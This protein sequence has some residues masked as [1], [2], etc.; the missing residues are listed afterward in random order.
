MGIALLAGLA[1]SWPQEFAASVLAGPRTQQDAAAAPALRYLDR[2]ASRFPRLGPHAHVPAH[3]PRARVLA[4]AAGTALLLGCLMLAELSW[5]VTAA[6]AFLV[7]F[8]LPLAVIDFQ[9]RRLPDA[10]TGPAYATV[11]ACLAG[12]SAAA[13]SWHMFGRALLGGALLAACYLMIALIWPGHMGAGDAKAAASVGTVL[14][15]IGWPVL[16]TGSLAALLLAGVC[17]G[18]LL[19][20]RRANIRAQIPFGPFLYGGAYL[21]VLVTAR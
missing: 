21:A 15:W 18:G 7:V 5:P 8:G 10:L 12:A 20:S 1:V 16:L 9:V 6:T 3:E 4:Y 19:I 11:I 17:G 13:G 2:A 14:A